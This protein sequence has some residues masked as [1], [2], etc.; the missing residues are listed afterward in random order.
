MI[1]VLVGVLTAVAIAALA[2][3]TRFDRDRSFYPTCYPAIRSIWT[4]PCLDRLP[5]VDGFRQDVSLS[6]AVVCVGFACA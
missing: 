6:R 4:D 2:R 5:R 1:P 3:S